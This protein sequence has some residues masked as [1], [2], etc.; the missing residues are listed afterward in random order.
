MLIF[1]SHFGQRVHTTGI[2]PMS[3]SFTTRSMCFTSCTKT[4]PL[5]FMSTITH[6]MQKFPGTFSVTDIEKHCTPIELTISKMAQ[7]CNKLDARLPMS[8]CKIC[9]SHLGNTKD[10]YLCVWTVE[11]I[12][13]SHFH[14][15]RIEGTWSSIHLQFGNWFLH[16]TKEGWSIVSLI[17]FEHTIT[18]DLYCDII[19]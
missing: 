6:S 2:L 10:C 15:V 17:F 7:I 14:G 5:L 8:E 18:V 19:Q 4:A 3:G 13:V 16:L 11:K 12:S 1:L 9:S